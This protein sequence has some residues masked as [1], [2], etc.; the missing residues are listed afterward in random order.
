[1][2]VEDQKESQYNLFNSFTEVQFL[3]NFI[4]L[5]FV[6]SRAGSSLLRGLL[7]VVGYRLLMLWAQALGMQAQYLL[8]H[9]LSCPST[10]GSSWTRG[11][12]HIP[13]TDRQ[14]LIHCTTKEA[15]SLQ[16]FDQSVCSSGSAKRAHTLW[17]HLYKVRNQTKLISVVT[18][19]DLSYP[20]GRWWL[21][22][23]QEFWVLVTFC[24]LI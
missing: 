20:W 24:L 15:P 5:W 1:M 7:F 9:G 19:Q 17:F 8:S 16:I 6:F 11:W 10:C 14:T 18:S 4:Y 13:C 22:G 21:G 12:T 2:F 23:E 3:N